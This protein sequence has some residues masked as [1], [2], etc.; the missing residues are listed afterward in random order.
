MS[1]RFWGKKTLLSL[2]PPD[3][4]PFPHIL[5]LMPKFPEILYVVSLS[6][7]EEAFQ[8]ATPQTFGL[9]LPTLPT[10]KLATVTTVETAGFFIPLCSLILKASLMW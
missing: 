2:S 6:L 7:L 10:L 9:S 3:C 1:A 4:S 5:V 8:L